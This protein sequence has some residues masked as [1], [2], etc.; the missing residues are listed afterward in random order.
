LRNVDCC[1]GF[2]RFDEGEDDGAQGVS[3]ESAAKILGDY[4][5]IGTWANDCS[6]PPS[7]DNFLTVYESQKNGDVKRTYFNGPNK[8]YNQ[9]KIVSASLMKDSNQL[10]Y[11][12]FALDDAPMKHIVVIVELKD[13]KYHVVFSKAVDGDTLVNAGDYANGDHKGTASPWQQRCH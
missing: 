1:L 10:F 9:Y 12:Q 8:I 5:M 6:K 11:E 13:D 3:A 7:N 2:L 4:G